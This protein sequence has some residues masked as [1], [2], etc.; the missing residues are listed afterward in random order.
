MLI[1]G[2]STGTVKATRT[3]QNQMYSSIFDLVNELIAGKKKKRK[4]ALK[5]VVHFKKKKTFADN[6]LTPISAFS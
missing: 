3:K 6:L 5:G 1:T 4:G 2:L